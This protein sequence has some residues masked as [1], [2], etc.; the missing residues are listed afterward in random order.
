MVSF[1]DLIAQKIEMALSLAEQTML[2]RFKL[3]EARRK[4]SNMAAW[5]TY[6]CKKGL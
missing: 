3:L 1:K 2:D 5:Q 6:D 4:V